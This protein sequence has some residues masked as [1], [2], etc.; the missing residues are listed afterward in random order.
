MCNIKQQISDV[1][2]CV[3][4]CGFSTYLQ[5]WWQTD[6]S[7]HYL[8]CT[9]SGTENFKIKKNSWTDEKKDSTIFLVEH[10]S[11]LLTHVCLPEDRQVI[12]CP[13][14]RGGKHA[15]LRGVATPA[16]YGMHPD[17]C[18]LFGDFNLQQVDSKIIWSDRES[19]KIVVRI[20]RV[21]GYCLPCQLIR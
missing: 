12:R 11:T 3:Q 1:L 9:Q 13:V 21:K 19:P 6:E 17:A 18:L 14:L 5:K 4:T 16:G 7:Y 2:I 20:L 10:C 8:R 15:A